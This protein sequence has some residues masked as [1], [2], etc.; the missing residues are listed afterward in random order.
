MKAIKPY[1]QEIVPKSVIQGCSCIYK[2]LY[3]VYQLCVWW[4]VMGKGVDVSDGAE[5]ALVLPICLQDGY[6]L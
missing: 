1:P 2:K 3:L 6:P 4:Q 5:D